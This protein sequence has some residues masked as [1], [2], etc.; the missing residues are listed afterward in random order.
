M[1]ELMALFQP[2]QPKTGGR[3]RG[4]KNRLS[5]AFLTALAEDF[6]QHGAEAI[7]ICR[8]E[9]P[10]EYLRVIAHLMPKELEITDN[11][12]HDI[13]DDELDRLITIAKRQLIEA[14]ARDAEGGEEQTVDRRSPALLPPV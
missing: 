7:K 12:L 4:V 11:R 9:K 6:E 5:H 3:A 2:G 10:N 13:T 8:M 1:G 14:A